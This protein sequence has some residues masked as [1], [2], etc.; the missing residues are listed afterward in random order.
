M[1]KNSLLADAVLLKEEL[2]NKVRV[3]QGDTSRLRIE[4]VR[5][6]AAFAVSRLSAHFHEQ[7]RALLSRDGMSEARD[8]FD[9]VSHGIPHHDMAGLGLS[10]RMEF[11]L[12]LGAAWAVENARLNARGDEHESDRRA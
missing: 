10:A 2:G 1:W 9:V 12:L 11:M 3:M 7:S 4:H 8:A 5:E 6:L